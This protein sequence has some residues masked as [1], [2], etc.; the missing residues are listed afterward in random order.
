MKKINLG[1]FISDRRKELGLSLKD[2][3]DFLNISSST[4]FKWEKNERTPDL[5]ILGDLAKIL[6]VDLISFV[7]EQVKFTDSEKDLHFNIDKF[8]L[9]F[10][11][12]RK[13]KGYT[14]V[15]LA[16]KLD[17]SYQTIS[18]WERKESLPN[19]YIL[20]KCA[21][22]FNISITELYYG[23]NIDN[24]TQLITKRKTRKIIII[25]I[26]S[27]VLVI[28]L[29][30]TLICIFANDD[31]NDSSSISDNSLSN[32]Q[33]S[34]SINEQSSTSKDTSLTDS[35]NIDISSSAEFDFSNYIIETNENGI[36]ILKY[37]G[38]EEEITLPEGVYQ[39]DYKA[40]FNNT[41]LR[42]IIIPNSLISIGENA[43]DSCFKLEEVILPDSLK[44]IESYAFTGCTSLKNINLSDDIKYL[45]AH[46]FANCESLQT[47]NIPKKINVIEY[48]TF[49]CC[50]SLTSITIPNNIETIEANAFWD[51]SLLESL[52]I[53]EG[54]KIIEHGAFSSCYNLKNISIPSSIEKIYDLAFIDCGVD[55]Y[56]L[57][58]NGLYLGNQNEPYIAF[59]GL[60]DYSKTKVKIHENTRIIVGS[61]LDDIDYLSYIYI[62]KSVT[63]IGG[64]LTR[65]KTIYNVYYQ[66]SEQQWNQI[67]IVDPNEK[68]LS[69]QFI[70]NY[71]F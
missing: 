31:H 20:V 47:I 2:I 36:K 69:A 49:Y 29:S 56:N 59:F 58:E 71:E 40:F 34:S 24:N 21:E 65:K 15:T 1:K 41:Y 68:L 28:A 32:I 48:A 19:I 53:E 43:F 51:C 5:A 38:Y 7:I 45:G 61:S 42:K 70:Y 17:V 46:A 50:R 55:A 67:E 23:L 27:I 52:Y 26:I 9:N 62:P 66:G 13:L 18:K 25:P 39:I 4:V 57:Y 12:I 3:A 33:E 44:R 35:S 30:I 22:L 37:N 14:L 10:S 64:Y 6:K 11:F 60:V 63:F 8:A 16:E 54:L